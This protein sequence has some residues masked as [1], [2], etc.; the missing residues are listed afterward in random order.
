ML[1]NSDVIASVAPG[2]WRRVLNSDGPAQVDVTFSARDTAAMRSQL[3]VWLRALDFCLRAE[4]DSHEPPVALLRPVSIDTVDDS[5]VSLLFDAPELIGDEILP[6]DRQPEDVL[7]VLRRIATS[8]DALHARHFIHGGLGLRSLW[9]MHDGSLRFPDAGLTHVLDGVAPAPKVSGAYLAP[10]VWRRSGVVPASDQY[11]LAV[12]AFELFTGRMRYTEDKANGVQSVQPTALEPGERLY[13][14]APRE[15]NEVM[16]RALS[17]EPSTRFATCLEFIEALQ[18]HAGKAMSLPTMHRFAGVST[19]LFTPRVVGLAAAAAVAV[20]VS[21]FVVRAGVLDRRPARLEVDIPRIAETAK[22]KVGDLRPLEA[23]SASGAASRRRT[24]RDNA[25][26]SSGGGTS[27]R[28]PALPRLP[29]SRSSSGGLATTSTPDAPRK[30]GVV[31]AARVAASEAVDMVVPP[32]STSRPTSPPS[33]STTDLS[34]RSSTG[35]SSPTSLPTR[36]GFSAT[37]S[38]GESGPTSP[39]A[40][41]SPSASDSAAGSTVPGG[42]RSSGSIR[43]WATNLIMGRRTTTIPAGAP[44][45]G[46]IKV[47]GPSGARFYV[48]GVLA[49]PIRGAVTVVEGEHDVDIVIPNQSTTR[50]RVI[51]HGGETV[52]VKL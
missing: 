45:T 18:G 24:Q 19:R 38:S 46:R 51:V 9:W 16:Q 2:E 20:S 49:R 35:G 37:A 14:G 15:L 4:V 17:T 12:I 10:E 47:S 34:P 48:D 32:L 41:G 36:T 27:V 6:P 29:D 39:M 33:A 52:A 42:T 8:L 13:P 5:S 28:I 1:I 40:S 43:E 23:I 31:D 11:S 22:E 30:S 7:E 44:P 26:I 50:R 21:M 3:D 25:S